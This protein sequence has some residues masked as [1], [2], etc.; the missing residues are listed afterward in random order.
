[1][2]WLDA[3]GQR[4]GISHKQSGEI[5]S[6]LDAVTE[7]LQRDYE[8]VDQL[9]LGIEGMIIP[10]GQNECMTLHWSRDGK[11][12]YLSGRST[13]LDLQAKPVNL[14]YKFFYSGY[15]KWLVSLQDW[16][17]RV[18]ESPNR[19]AF[20]TDI[21]AIYHES[22]KPESER[23]TMKQP[24]RARREVVKAAPIVLSLMGLAGKDGRTFTGPEIAEALSQKYGSMMYILDEITGP[25]EISH[26]ADTK[27]ASGRR[28]GR[29]WTQKFLQAMGYSE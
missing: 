23:K 1:M 10:T 17:I 19:E 27:L 6:G 11:I 21:L 13:K 22:L 9:Y 12:A 25:G 8:G 20:V 28:V 15:R 3:Q 14:P 2:Y 5:L 24:I 7:Q 16:G 26:I 4:Q 29:A 18:F